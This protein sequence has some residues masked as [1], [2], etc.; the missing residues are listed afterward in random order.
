VKGGLLVRDERGREF[1]LEAGQMI[2]FFPERAYRYRIA[3]PSSAL[4]LQWFAFAGPQA[5]H[6]CESLGLT[7]ER[8]V[9]TVDLGPHWRD[10]ADRLHASVGGGDPIRQQRLLYE[11]IEWLRVGAPEEAPGRSRDWLEHC[12]SYLRLHYAE[13]IRVESLAE[14]AG[15]HRSYLSDMFRKTYG[16]SPKQFVTALRMTNA[17]ALLR[18]G[19]S[20]VQDIAATVGYPELF[21]FT[22]AFTKHYG[23][24]P[25]AYRR[26]GAT[27][28]TAPSTP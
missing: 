23:L 20:P 11:L 3:D 6:L 12:A 18:D 1:R 7:P 10:V 8:P 24:S 25:T 27:S 26:G 5:P 13:P 4:R 16:M 19:D 2:C 17:A 9:L 22:R 21:A 15:V 14:D 28:A